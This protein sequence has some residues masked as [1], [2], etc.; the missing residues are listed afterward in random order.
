[1]YAYYIRN[2]TTYWQKK[3][4]NMNDRIIIGFF[5]R[6]IIGNACTRHMVF[7]IVL[8]IIIEEEEHVNCL[9]LYKPKEMENRFVK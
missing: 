7:G 6:C 9:V 1:M 8:Y 3:N 5:I 4:T 2:C